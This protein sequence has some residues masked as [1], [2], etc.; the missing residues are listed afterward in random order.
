[1]FTKF[2]SIPQF[3]NVVKLAHRKCP[4]EHVDGD[5][6]RAKIKLHGT[7]AGVMISKNGIVQAQKRTGRITSKNDNFEFA[8]WVEDNEAY[9]KSLSH[10]VP[11]TSDY[12]VI[13]GE[14][15]GPGIQKKVSI[16]EIPMKSFFVFSIYSS[17]EDIQDG[18]VVI[19]PEVIG[20]ALNAGSPPPANMYVIPWYEAKHGVNKWKLFFNNTANLKE[21]IALWEEEIERIE[22]CDP[23]VE[24][25]FGVKGLGEGL[26][27]H[28]VDK[29]ITFSDFPHHI[30]KVKGQKHSVN[31]QKAPV[32][33]EPEVLQA[34]SDFCDMFVTE[35]RL[36]QM[37]EMY[38]NNE[39]DI[40]L[41]GKLIGVTA[42]DIIKES[43]DERAVMKC[44]WKIVAREIG[45]RVKDWYFKKM[46]F[47]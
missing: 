22:D 16:S 39:V 33:I 21:N 11:E 14:W 26:V 31:K 13:Y 6:F 25:A 42:Q 29:V 7:N 36:N 41:V 4:S 27:F 3:H 46:E 45:Q 40:K 28:N 19:E 35:N 43:V 30:F 38:L 47:K 17:A 44:Q 9:F 24:L 18:P 8:K 1:M 5:L 2:P 37:M 12:I 15:A 10:L 34:S 32:L 23:F 20:Q